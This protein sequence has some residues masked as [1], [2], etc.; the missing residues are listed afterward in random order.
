MGTGGTAGPHHCTLPYLRELTSTDGIVQAAP[1]VQV[2]VCSLNI[3]SL[4]G[5]GYLG[6]LPLPTVNEMQGQKLT[7]SAN[8]YSRIYAPHIRDTQVRHSS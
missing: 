1:A 3:S 7:D 2:A 6:L 4:G 5:T 8:I